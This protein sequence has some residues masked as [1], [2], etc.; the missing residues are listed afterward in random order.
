LRSFKS[1]T[2]HELVKDLKITE[3]WV[4]STFIKGNGYSIWRNKNHPL[5]I[6]SYKFYYQ[7]ANYIENNPVKKKYVYKPEDW[8]YSSAN[9]IQLLKLSS[10]I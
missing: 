6:F 1:Y 9:K 7:K 3:P 10:F 5:Q 4:L 2:S 8:K